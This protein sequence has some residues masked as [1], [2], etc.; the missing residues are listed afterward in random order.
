MSLE[1]MKNR[2]IYNG[3][4]SPQSR[5]IKDKLRSMLSAIKTSYQSAIFSQYPSLKV[6]DKGL[7]NP[8]TQNEDYDT[9]M[10]STD[11]DNNYSPGVTFVWKN[12]DTYWIVFL[13]DKT[14]LAYFRGECRRCDYKIQWVDGNREVQETLAS[15]IG[16]SATLLKT[17][18]V[19]QAN[20]ATDAPNAGIKILVPDNERNARFFCRYQKFLL[21]R[22]TYIIEEVDNLSMPGVIQLN[23]NENY[24]NPITDDVENN[25]S[26]AWNIVPVVPTQP[27][28]YAIDGP[29]TIKPQFRAEFE[30]IISGGRWII[31][32]NNNTNK[33]PLPA[34]FVEND[35]T[36][37]TITVY[38][39]SMKSGNFTIGY[40]M[41]S[42]QL[43]Q[44]NVLVE[45]FM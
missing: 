45:S 22:V 16:P 30:S 26:N 36:Q 10:I 13:Q 37:K 24:S 42:G 2:L 31:V 15:V 19:S 14:E 3:G 40:L 8:I 7:F 21:K 35:H 41:P 5:M 39:D 44:R 43:Y 23:A 4:A 17:S 27:T 32:E 25:L 18:D 33:K 6:E 34:K 29:R 9:K 1:A 28:D 12:T 20:A 38:W 11:F